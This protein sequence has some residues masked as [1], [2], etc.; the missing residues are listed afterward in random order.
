MTLD[1]R[2][3]DIARYAF[4]VAFADDHSIDSAELAFIERLALADGRIDEA[5]RDTLRAILARVDPHS[6]APDARAAL[7]AFRSRHGI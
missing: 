6:L 7:D 3:D 4:L 1:S 2:A 5:E